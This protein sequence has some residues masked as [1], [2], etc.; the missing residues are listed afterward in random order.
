MK[1]SLIVLF[2]LLVASCKSSNNPDVSGLKKIDSIVIDRSSAEE[3]ISYTINNNEVNFAF[4]NRHSYVEVWNARQLLD[5]F[6][7]G[8]TIT[9]RYCFSVSHGALCILN[10]PQQNLTIYNH[11]DTR[12]YDLPKNQVCI[13]FPLEPKLINNSLVLFALPP[14]P[15]IQ[16]DDISFF[17]L[18]HFVQYKINDTILTVQDTFGNFPPEYTKNL[19]GETFPATCQMSDSVC[20]YIYGAET[21]IHIRNMDTH[22]T[23]NYEVN[24]IHKNYM[25]PVDMDSMHSLYYNKQHDIRTDKNLKLMYDPVS[26]N[27]LL[28]QTLKIE[29]NDKN[30][31]YQPLP[32]DKSVLISVIDKSFKIIRQYRAANLIDYFYYNFYY[33]NNVLYMHRMYKH[34]A[35]IIIDAYQ[36]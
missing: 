9:D 12:Q 17:A 11:N 14:H 20:A 30:E 34:N 26:S 35:K 1:Y 27:F 23:R 29:N 19:Y 33:Y 31:I 3:A 7:I 10:I 6:Y 36:I 13:Q 22:T 15:K 28:M 16:K 21:T 2:V 8:N 32:E 5:S 24:G 18:V 25:Y 4:I